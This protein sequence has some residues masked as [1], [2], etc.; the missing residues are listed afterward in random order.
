MDNEK[1]LTIKQQEGAAGG[2]EN[3]VTGVE[4]PVE[5]PSLPTVSGPEGPSD[6]SAAYAKLLAEKR[7][8]YDRLL[9]KQAEIENLRKRTQREK[10][11][12]RQH[13]TADLIRTLLPVLDGFERALKQRDPSIPDSFYKGMELIYKELLEVLGRAGLTAIESEGKTFDPHYHQAVES[14]PLPTGGTTKC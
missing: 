9:R 3:N 14:V 7:E 1:E 2:A 13:A 5:A 11:E 4:A 8:L 6:L 12:F 10:E